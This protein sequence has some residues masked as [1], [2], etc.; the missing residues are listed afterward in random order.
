MV[1][2]FGKNEKRE[3]IF[4]KTKYEACLSETNSKPETR[5]KF[6]DL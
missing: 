5:E 6:I 2:F 3:P 1:C 4:E